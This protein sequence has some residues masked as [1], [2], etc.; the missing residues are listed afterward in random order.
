MARRPYTETM[1]WVGRDHEA[2][3]QLKDK[4]SRT[5]DLDTLKGTKNSAF[6]RT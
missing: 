5:R 6:R 1:Y 3:T 2:V 4:V